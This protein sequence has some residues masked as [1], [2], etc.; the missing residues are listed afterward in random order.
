MDWYQGNGSL[1]NWEA[2]NVDS[3]PEDGSEQNDRQRTAKK[4]IEAVD[5]R[6]VQS[7]AGYR[8]TDNT[9]AI[10]ASTVNPLSI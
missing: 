6:L 7:G 8:V 2:T 5:R 9:E 3:K 1:V 4:K 10:S